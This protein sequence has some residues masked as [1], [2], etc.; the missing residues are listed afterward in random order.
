MVDTTVPS[1]GGYTYLEEQLP[2]S[3][4]SAV[5]Y[6]GQIGFKCGDYLYNVRVFAGESKNA[7]QVYIYESPL[8]GMT[9]N[10]YSE[11]SCL[12]KNTASE[13]IKKFNLNKPKIAYPNCLIGGLRDLHF[14][15]ETARLKK[16]GPTECKVK[17]SEESEAK[18]CLGNNRK[19][20]LEPASRGD[21]PT[22]SHQESSQNLVCQS[23]L[24]SLTSTPHHAAE[25]VSNNEKLTSIDI[26]FPFTP[27]KFWAQSLLI[28]EGTKWTFFEQ[29]HISLCQSELEKL[30]YGDIIEVCISIA[31]VPQKDKEILS[32]QQLFEKSHNVKLTIEL[33][34]NE[35]GVKQLKVKIHASE[36]LKKKL[37][38]SIKIH[39]LGCMFIDLYVKNPVLGYDTKIQMKE[40]PVKKSWLFNTDSKGQHYEFDLGATMAPKWDSKSKR[41]DSVSAEFSQEVVRLVSLIR[42]GDRVAIQ[43]ENSAETF[44][45]GPSAVDGQVRLNANDDF[46]GKSNDKSIALTALFNSI[47]ASRKVEPVDERKQELVSNSA[48]QQTEM[49]IKPNNAVGDDELPQI[50]VDKSNESN[51]EAQPLNKSEATQNS[52]VKSYEQ[53]AL[54]SLTNNDRESEH[55]EGGTRQQESKVEVSTQQYLQSIIDE[56]EIKELSDKLDKAIKCD[57]FSIKASPEGLKTLPNSASG[58]SATLNQSQSSKSQYQE[59]NVVEEPFDLQNKRSKVAML[60]SWVK[61]KQASEAQLNEFS[62]METRDIKTMFK[63]KCPVPKGVELNNATLK[64]LKIMMTE[65]KKNA[66]ISVVS[67][68]S[69]AEVA[70]WKSEK[71]KSE[72]QFSFERR[73]ENRLKHKTSAQSSNVL[74]SMIDSK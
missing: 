27:A 31:I 34:E 74:I 44:Y 60:K 7:V 66:C 43:F 37:P 39:E 73:V 59:E 15:S 12:Q 20:T 58:K 4:V 42:R 14:I 62:T 63:Q 26:S 9:H 33:K 19:L 32:K 28:Q 46:F 68:A 6:G 51:Q 72:I 36:S 48:E 54:T 69:E 18:N 25:R 29:E 65:A 10:A 64:M 71:R 5:G 45:V 70:A 3:W 38:Y 53:A 49:D 2:P 22:K 16:T 13:V 24:S 1:S 57:A 30:D 61:F 8:R 21:N 52:L 23:E 41:F 35:K 17:Q 67:E 40:L 50:T 11:H 47:Y 56:S 55:Y